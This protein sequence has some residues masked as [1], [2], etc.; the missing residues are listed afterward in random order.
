MADVLYP[1]GYGTTMVTMSQL[2][3]RHMN[4]MHPEF[5]A[6]LFPWIEA[7]GGDIGIGGGHRTV[8][9]AKVGFAPPGKSFH[10]SQTFASG[11]SC[12]CAVDLVHV[13][14]GKVHRSPTWAEVPAQGSAEADKWRVHCNVRGEPWHMQPIE[15]DGYDSWVKAGRLEPQPPPPPPPPPVIVYPPITGAVMDSYLDHNGAIYALYSDAGYKTYIP[16]GDAW[17]LQK[18]LRKLSDQP[19]IPTYKADKVLMWAT[20]PVFGPRATDSDEYGA[21]G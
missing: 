17:Q 19:E 9:P 16:R 20:G 5:A 15:I 4:H 7:Q 18:D 21:S 2:K 6:R 3:A 13:N 14:P 1:T 11:V 10:Q 12:Y 8:Q